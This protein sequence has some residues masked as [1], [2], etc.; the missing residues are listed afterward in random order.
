MNKFLVATLLGAASIMLLAGLSQGGNAPVAQAV[1]VQ[2]PA[3]SPDAKP[4]E[5]PRECDNAANITT[6]CIY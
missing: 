1:A 6:A 2:M 4:A 3:I 5:L